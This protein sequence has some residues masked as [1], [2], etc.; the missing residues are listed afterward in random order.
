VACKCQIHPASTIDEFGGIINATAEFRRR[1]RMRKFLSPNF[2][3]GT[4]AVIFLVGVLDS[5]VIAHEA[6]KTKCTQAS[7]NAV[8][9]DVQAMKDGEAKRTAAK[10][11]KLAENM[12]ASKDKEGCVSHMHKA[13]EAIEE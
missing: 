8:R 9:A 4:V 11:M 6:H 10:E 13:M 7:I 3:F 5:A 1:A 12:M 2:V